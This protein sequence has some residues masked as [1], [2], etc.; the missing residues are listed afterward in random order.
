MT[1]IVNMFDR[2]KVNDDEFRREFRVTREV[3]A[4]LEAK[5]GAKLGLHQAI[6]H[7]G[8]TQSAFAKR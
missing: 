1:L 8:A 7:F 2:T 4:K 5:L 6:A 3:F